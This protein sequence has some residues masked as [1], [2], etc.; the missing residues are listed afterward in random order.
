MWVQRAQ[1]L[2]QPGSCNSLCAKA[3]K[4]FGKSDS[5][6]QSISADKTQSLEQPEKSKAKVNPLDNLGVYLEAL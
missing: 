2:P 6:V 3:I 5:R 4:L 1:S